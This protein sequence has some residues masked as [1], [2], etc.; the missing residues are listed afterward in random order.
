MK[1]LIGS[2]GSVLPSR[3]ISPSLAARVRKQIYYL[4][5]I[6]RA[7][8]KVFW[9]EPPQLNQCHNYSC[10]SQITWFL[11]I[12]DLLGAETLK[13]LRITCFSHNKNKGKRGLCSFSSFG[14]C[15]G[16]WCCCLMDKRTLTG[17]KK[18]VFGG[19]FLAWVIPPVISNPNTEVT[20]FWSQLGF[21]SQ[22]FQPA[23]SS[24][25]Q[26][27]GVPGTLPLPP[28]KDLWGTANTQAWGMDPACALRCREGQDDQPPFQEQDQGKSG[29]IDPCSQLHHPM[30][31]GC[32]TFNSISA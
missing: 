9:V 28:N 11:Q 32:S 18:K 20:A 1:R 30:A 10:H 6:S 12:K 25:L 26:H 23:G 14:S 2:E 5:L 13:H 4:P 8:T 27:W 29:C 3:I 15:S 21:S 17:P 19:F 24:F 16:G 31:G 22:S 7:E